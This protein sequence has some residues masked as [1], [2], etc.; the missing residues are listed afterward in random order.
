MRRP[1]FVTD[2]QVAQLPAFQE[3]RRSLDAIGLPYETHS[4]IQS[5][6]VEENVKAGVRLFRARN[7]EGVIAFGG[8][9]ALDVGKAVALMSGQQRRIWEF[10]DRND[11]WKRV[12]T[13][14]IARVI[15][16][17]TTA[18]TGSE[19]GRASVITDVRDHVKKIIFHPRMMPTCVILDPALTVGLPPH[20]TA[21]TG[22]DA[23]SH[24]LEAYCATGFHPMADGI[25]AEAMRLIAEALPRAYRDGSDLEARAQMLV[26]SSMGATAFQKGLGA[27]HAMSHPC[28]ALLGSHHG[29]T[30]AVV[31]PYV[32]A[33]NRPV[34]AD[35]LGR[36]A[37]YLGLEQASFAG[38]LDWVLELR[39]QL[40]IP[41]RVDALGVREE[42]VEALAKQAHVDPSAATNPRPLS[43]ADFA[44][45]FRSA[46]AGELPN[47]RAM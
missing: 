25:A 21:A 23:L 15:A 36:L 19:V 11:W 32:L 46:L 13:S 24:A 5:N 12:D 41:N 40:G 45:L 38:V 33:W 14:H 26:A 34:I 9:S 2:P 31:M 1:L 29:L 37:A 42:H 18:G 30:N 7:C 22:M 3:C 47:A 16:V 43:V 17:P 44:S 27:M 4:D 8:G 28:S 39:A 6:P 35:R 10:E 20:V